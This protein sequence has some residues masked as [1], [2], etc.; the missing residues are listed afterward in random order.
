MTESFDL[1]CLVKQIEEV[2]SQLAPKSLNLLSKRLFSDA[3]FYEV[4]GSQQEKQ[5][6]LFVCICIGVI[7]VVTFIF[8]KQL[9]NFIPGIFLKWQSALF[10]LN[11]LM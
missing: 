4:D 5:K 10:I 3:Y 2:A 11:G 7:P 1:S 9:F 8:T 6:K